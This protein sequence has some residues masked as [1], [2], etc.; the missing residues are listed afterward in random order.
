MRDWGID[1]LIKILRCK[2][3]QTLDCQ[4]DNQAFCR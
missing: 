4:R 2:K 1:F 3:S